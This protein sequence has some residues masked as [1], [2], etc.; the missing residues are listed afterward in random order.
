M[1]ELVLESQLNM[2][3]VALSNAQVHD[4]FLKPGH[5]ATP[6]LSRLL[7]GVGTLLSLPLSLS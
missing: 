1:A 5:A 7:G 6:A 3:N 4:N 2:K